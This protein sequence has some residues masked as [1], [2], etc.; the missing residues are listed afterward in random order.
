[1]QLCMG[2]ALQTRM[3]LAEVYHAL[4]QG[5]F[6]FEGVIPAPQV[7][8]LHLLW[9]EIRGSEFSFACDTSNRKDAAIA[10]LINDSFIR[11]LGGELVGFDDLL[12]GPNLKLRNE[13]LVLRW[14]ACA[15]AKYVAGAQVHRAVA[16]IE[17]AEKSSLA[18]RLMKKQS[19]AGALFSVSRLGYLHRQGSSSF[20]RDRLLLPELIRNGRVFQP[21]VAFEKIKICFEIRKLNQLLDIQRDENR[22]SAW[23]DRRIVANEHRQSQVN[24]GNTFQQADLV[25]PWLSG[26]GFSIGRFADDTVEFPHRAVGSAEMGA[27]HLMLYEIGANRRI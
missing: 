7:D 6:L 5:S 12:E 20:W 18:K 21:E 27:G 10:W 19:A 16:S 26:V 14:Q 25:L 1:M 2:F 24:R 22:I 9:G 15:P 23:L 3:T 11:S 17:F 4:K 13:S 8:N